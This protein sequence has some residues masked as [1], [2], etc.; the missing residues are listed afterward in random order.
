MHKRIIF[1]DFENFT[2]IVEEIKEPDT[3]VIVL[4]G[5]KQPTK[6]FTFAKGLVD[7]VSS[8][9]LL[10]VKAQGDNALD[11]FIAYYL[12]VYINRN[13][14]LEYAIC[15][16]DQGYD[17][18]IRHLVENGI[19]INRI[20]IPKENKPVEKAV[21]GNLKKSPVKPDRNNNY[22]KAKDNLSKSDKR[23]GK[24]KKLESYLMALF[25]NSLQPEGITE[26]I[27]KLKKNKIIEVE[28]D[29]IKYK[30]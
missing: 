18:L 23:P 9:E 1:V 7:Y 2:Q 6:P 3:K 4:L 24:L 13:R 17:P 19:K 12:G 10:K 11:F 8:V 20:E 21:S 27:N 28:G 15:S 5:S 29:K 14:Q 26:I 30:C 16:N 22:K 25:T